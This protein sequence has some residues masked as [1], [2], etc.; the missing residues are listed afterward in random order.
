MGH[1]IL[2][3]ETLPVVE[4]AGQGQRPFPRFHQFKDGT[5]PS[6][7]ALH[8]V[9]HLL[10]AVGHEHAQPQA[11]PEHL[12]VN[13][14]LGQAHFL[15]AQ[16]IE[17]HGLQDAQRPHALN[18]PLRCVAVV[19]DVVHVVGAGGR[20]GVAQV[21]GEFDAGFVHRELLPFDLHSVTLRLPSD[22]LRRP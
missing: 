22:P 13:V 2:G 11:I 6:G 21:V 4:G 9:S 20:C 19:V 15:R 10:P 18:A 7:H 17:W 16:I 3:G 1:I 5:V 14:I 8:D 12:P